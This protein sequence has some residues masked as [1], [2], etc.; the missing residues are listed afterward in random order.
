MQNIR[1]RRI[2][3][4]SLLVFF[5]VVGFPWFFV[6]MAAFPSTLYSYKNTINE[7]KIE[8]S[9]KFREVRN[10]KLIRQSFAVV[11]Y[12]LAILCLI[13]VAMIYTGMISSFRYH[14]VIWLL[15]LVTSALV[16]MFDYSAFSKQS[17]IFDK[18]YHIMTP[19]IIL[20]L[21]IL[22][23]ATPKINESN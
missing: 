17:S 2:A 3:Q 11:L 20:I 8:G 18:I 21:S 5:V 14:Q 19:S 13:G 23:V 6:K 9:E 7:Y 1:S 4:I 10:A 12:M 22:K 16:I 15:V